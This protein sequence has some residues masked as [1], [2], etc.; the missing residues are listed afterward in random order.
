MSP[1]RS[2]AAA[3]ETRD[4]IVD[5]AISMG[6]LDGLESLSFGRVA[7]A[8]QLSKSG[9]IRHFATKEELQLATLN[10]ARERFRLAIWA[11]VADEQPGLVRLRAV[12]TAWLDYLQSCPLPGG[13]LVTAAATEF[14]SRPGAVRD[15]VLADAALWR[16]V[17]Q[18]DIEIASRT[19]ELPADVDAAQMVFEL[20]G[21]ALAVNQAAQL[22]EDHGAA[23]RGG[24]AVD[25][26][27][28]PRA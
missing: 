24:T 19:G 10:A 2:A 13:C 4:S 12:M 15:A 27:L 28:V 20:G 11:P 1:R 16:S 5:N 25:R 14:D 8:V 7:D 6:S 18:R 17:L 26:I 3:Q 21:I 9:V 23:A 22:H